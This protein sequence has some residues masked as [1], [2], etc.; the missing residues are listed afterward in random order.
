MTWL[1]K[2]K[3]YQCNQRHF[4]KQQGKPT[5]AVELAGANSSI[6]YLLFGCKLWPNKSDQSRNIL[7]LKL[8]SKRQISDKFTHLDWPIAPWT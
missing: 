1:T 5:V 4:T 7:T 8:C 6:H 2:V 3:L